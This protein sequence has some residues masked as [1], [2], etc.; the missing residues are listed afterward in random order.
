MD[1]R[2]DILNDAVAAW[3]ESTR[4]EALSGSSRTALFDDVRSL[5]KGAQAPFVPSVTRAWRWAFLGSL[6]VVALASMLMIGG[7]HRPD[8]SGRLTASKV[9]GHLV[10]TL[11]NGKTDHVIYRSTNPE[12]FDRLAPIKMSQ[13]TYNEVV[14]GGPTLVFYR[15]D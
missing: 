1:T 7:D 14:T 12:S 15:I 3:R 6:P 5:G 11:A 10:F 13:N 9:N 2:N 8:V 4:D